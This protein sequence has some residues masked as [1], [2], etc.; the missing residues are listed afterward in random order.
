[1]SVKGGML[2]IVHHEISVEEARGYYEDL[3]E[4]TRLHLD[5]DVAGIEV[6]NI[7]DAPL[8]ADIVISLFALPG[9]HH[10]AVMERYPG[11]VVG[12]IN[13]AVILSHVERHYPRMGG[14]R[15]RLVLVNYAAKGMRC[16]RD[17]TLERIRAMLEGL[18]G[19]RVIVA[20]YDPRSVIECSQGS[21]YAPLTLAP[22]K[23]TLTLDSE[24]CPR[25]PTLL[26]GSMDLVVSWIAGVVDGFQSRG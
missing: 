23:L 10:A 14:P 17:S 24:G 16:E 22:N 4:R 19:A 25:L 7:N 11:R 21:I 3:V 6:S 13:P 2:L 15:S 8:E 1:M 26:E 20:E 5:T 12:P 18:L 9:G